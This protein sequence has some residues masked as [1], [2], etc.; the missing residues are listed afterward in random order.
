MKSQ[1]AN[2][3]TVVILED[4]RM[5]REQLVHLIEKA[6]DMTVTGEADNIRDG[7]AVIQQERPQIAI[8]D[9]TLRGSSGIELLKDLRAQGI[10][11]PVLILS[12]HDESLYAERALRAGAKGY[13]TKHEASENV[14]IAIREV[15]RGEIYLNPRFMSRVMS[16]MM[17]GRGEL[18]QP[19]DQLADRELEVFE[20]IG[21]GL[22]TR[23]IGAKLGLGITTVNT[24]R[25]RIKEK[26]KLENAARLRFEASRWVQERE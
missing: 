5:F 17:T 12:M 3:I 8:V 6:G 15:L 23:E 18:K 26:L 1:A 21:R 25:T 24:Y 2:K 7:F 13:V 10:D 4:H 16:R 22:T 11:V 9:I 20:L 19:I 14:L